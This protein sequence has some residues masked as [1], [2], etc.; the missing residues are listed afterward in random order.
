M[1]PISRLTRPISLTLMLMAWAS[2]IWAHPYDRAVFFGQQWYQSAEVGVDR[3]CGSYL[4]L[5]RLQIVS[6]ELA[7]FI[8]I[9]AMALGTR[10]EPTASVRGVFENGFAVFTEDSIPRLWFVSNGTHTWDSTLRRA[11]VYSLA[12]MHGEHH[13]SSDRYGIT[14]H[15]QQLILPVRDTPGVFRHLVLEWSSLEGR[16]W[17]IGESSLN[18]LLSYRLDARADA[19]IPMSPGGA[20]PGP[21]LRYSPDPVDRSVAEEAIAWQGDL[22]AF[23]IGRPNTDMTDLP[24]ISRLQ[25]IAHGN[26]RDWWVIAM[27]GQQRARA[28]ASFLLAADGRLTLQQ[29]DTA[30]VPFHPYRQSFYRS[31]GAQL[32]VSQQGDRIA[33]H[34]APD[35]DA[36]AP[37]Y[38]P[39][40]ADNSGLVIWDFDRCTG[41]F[42]RSHDVDLPYA[43]TG[44]YPWPGTGPIT[45]Y[46][47]SG[48][49]FSPSGRYLYFSE[50]S[51][52]GR[53]DLDAADLLASHKQVLAPH[54]LLGRFSRS[55]DQNGYAPFN[56][57]HITAGKNGRLLHH[58]G[59]SYSNIT[60]L[61][62]LDAADVSEVE[63]GLLGLETLCKNSNQFIQ[64]Y[65]QLY[66]HPDSGC[67]TLGIDGWQPACQSWSSGRTDT[68]YV[69]DYDGDGLLDTTHWRGRALTTPGIE[70]ASVRTSA[71]CD[72]L[73]RAHVIA[74]DAHSARLNFVVL[75]VRDTL[76]GVVIRAD[77]TFDRRVPRVGACDELV[78]YEVRAVSST[79][80]Q[81]ARMQALRVWPSPA[82]GAQSVQVTLPEG[83][84]GGVL[85]VHDAAGREQASVTVTD[86]AQEAVL[87][88]EVLPQGIY[89]VVLYTRDGVWRGRGVRL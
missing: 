9:G 1:R 45:A 37:Y 51:Y 47:G 35:P 73:W 10:N 63:G 24:T 87:E 68:V 42:N 66:D 82:A 14:N 76:F 3:F 33:F 34:C 8:P 18:Q 29:L 27:G 69:C 74:S 64:P 22:D 5:D 62:N 83:H 48:V 17:A 15:S 65:F 28:M 77:T 41:M 44:A 21:L 16:R 84:G 11:T 2:S 53:V 19:A 75:S 25:A 58:H 56:E 4:P 39:H 40:A 88:P 6:A 12:P 30:A 78:R 67:D 89:T 36:A 26:G 71:G 13:G 49:A 20:G 23:V 60:T 52:I 54:S 80:E 46:P 7:D 50:A 85:R 61:S 55:T 79:R 86:G 70:Y 59:G 43:F 72:S 57:F 32:H 38:G 81:L 31:G